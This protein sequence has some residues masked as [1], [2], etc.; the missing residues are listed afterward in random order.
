[1]KNADFE[2]AV[3]SQVLVIP[4]LPGEKVEQ[5]VFRHIAAR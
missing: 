4:T 5:L 1:V 2:R 3:R